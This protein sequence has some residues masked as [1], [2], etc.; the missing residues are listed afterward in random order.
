MD[1][2]CTNLMPGNSIVSWATVEDPGDT[3]FLADYEETCLAGDLDEADAYVSTLQTSCHPQGRWY[4]RDEL[5]RL[6]HSSP[7]ISGICR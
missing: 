6:S 7:V 3:D 5:R 1:L 4:L 2:S